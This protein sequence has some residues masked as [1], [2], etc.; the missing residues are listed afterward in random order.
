[1]SALDPSQLLTAHR[2]VC[3]VDVEGFGSHV[4]ESAYCWPVDERTMHGA[5][6]RID[7]RYVELKRIA[8]GLYGID[9]PTTVSGRRAR[10]SPYLLQIPL[11]GE[12]DFE[13]DG[14]PIQVA[15]GS[16]ILLSPPCKAVRRARPGWTLLLALR[17]E[18]VRGRVEARTRRPAGQ[19]FAFHPLI[20]AHCGEILEYCM[21]LVEAIDRGSVPASQALT[22]TLENGLVDLLLELQPHTHA[23]S[24]Q[25]AESRTALG[26][27][28]RVEDH[29]R[30]S[31]GASMTLGGLARVADCSARTLQALFAEYCGMSPMD[32][33]RRIR[34]VHARKR[35]RGGAKTCTVTSVAAEVGYTSQGRFASDYRQV[36]AELPSQ[37]LRATRKRA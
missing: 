6:P 32:F 26:R 5:S 29:V 31:L 4:A 22:R 23:R 35:L 2:V 7:Y 25:R 28:Q 1:M 15:P 18:L 20:T 13:L 34:L 37:T 33:V 12:L 27:I 11:D 19:R 16:G 3:G 36:F 17:P 24:V 14:R 10:G 21:L 30:A 8:V 9:V